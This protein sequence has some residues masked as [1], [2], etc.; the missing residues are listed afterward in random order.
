MALLALLPKFAWISW[1]FAAGGLH[2]SVDVDRQELY[3][4]E[5]VQ[6][7]YSLRY[8]GQRADFSD[9]TATFTSPDLEEVSQF[10]SPTFYQMSYVNGV[11]RSETQTRVTKVLRPKR[12]GTIQIQNISVTLDGKTYRADDL[13]I[14]VL[15]SQGTRGARPRGYGMGSP[16]NMSG[17]RSGKNPLQIRAEISKLKAV[18]GEQLIVSFYS[19]RRG[20]VGQLEAIKLPDFKGFLKDDPELPVLKRPQPVGPTNLDGWTYEKDL[21]ARYVVYPLEAGTLTIDTLQVRGVAYPDADSIFGNYFNVLNPKRVDAKNEPIQVEVTDLPSQGRPKSFQGAVGDINLQSKLD[22]TEAKVGDP[23]TLLLRLE[24]R[25]N[26][27]SIEAPAVSWP[28]GIELFDSKSVGRSSQAGVGEKSFEYILIPRKPGEFKLPGIEFSFFN[29]KSRTYETK[30]IPQLLLKA[31]GTPQSNTATTRGATDWQA[32]RDT[33]TSPQMVTGHAEL[34]FLKLA[35]IEPS[36]LETLGIWRWWFWM[37]GMGLFVFLIQVATH[38]GRQLF[39]TARN[40]AQLQGAPGAALARRELTDRA[41]QLTAQSTYADL[42]KAYTA[43]ENLLFEC[44]SE[45]L[46]TPARA[47]TRED[48]KVRLGT[49]WAQYEEAFRNADVIRYGKPAHLA[50]SAEDLQ[51]FRNL[52]PWVTARL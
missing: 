32:A 15:P 26:F 9:M 43:M 16:L 25:A 51:Q 5:S 30:R 41:K 48:L 8:D 39:R 7:V 40:R 38:K 18:K 27:A 21:L 13:S 37:A 34:R 52:L 20:Q 47:L 45:T 35:P 1:A 42:S 36:R 6:L 24:G 3:E 29:P 14:Q 12:K 2:L 46:K 11:T 10:D 50:I 31:T 44:I 33:P 23:V 28:E 4:D 19:Y 49:E 17:K 22:R